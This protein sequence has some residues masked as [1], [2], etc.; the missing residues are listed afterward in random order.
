[1]RSGVWSSDRSS[2][3][4]AADNADGGLAAMAHVDRQAVDSRVPMDRFGFER[5][6]GTA[7]A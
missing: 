2:P 7:D 3:R 5:P 4:D 1:M 6:A